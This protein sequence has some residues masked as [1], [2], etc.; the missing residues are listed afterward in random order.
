MEKYYGLT[1]KPAVESEWKNELLNHADFEGWQF[2]S[3]NSSLEDID[4]RKPL[5]WFASFQDILGKNKEGKVKERFEKAYK[6]KWDCII[7]DEYHFGA[8]REEP[9]ELYIEEPNEAPK[10]LDSKVKKFH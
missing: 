5:C 6:I 7:L 3:R 9:K 4:F 1:W 2:L 10:N 8:W